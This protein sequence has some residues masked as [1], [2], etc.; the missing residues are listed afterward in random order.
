MSDPHATKPR[1]SLASRVR[2]FGYAF[3]GVVFML[4]T[5]HNACCT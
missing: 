2:S 1:F 4:R 5:Q 3:A